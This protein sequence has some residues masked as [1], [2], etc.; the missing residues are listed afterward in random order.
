MH[1]LNALHTIDTAINSS[2]DLRFTYQ[3]LLEQ[4]LTL[5]KAGA[6]CVIF[7]DSELNTKKL[8]TSLGFSTSEVELKLILQ[9]DP[10]ADRAFIERH[11]VR[12]TREEIISE[13]FPLAGLLKGEEIISYY[14]V[15][16]IVKGYVKGVLDLFF[17][18]DDEMD[19]EVS[20]FLE[21]IAQQAAIALESS[22]NFERLQ[23][24]N[25]E[26]LQAYDDTLAGWVNFLDLRDEKTGG[27][28][29]RVLE[30]TLKICRAFGFSSQELL[31]IHRGVLLHDIGKIGVPDN[32]LNKPG[33]LT[34]AE[35]VIMKKHPV[36]AYQ[37]L[38]P[39]SYL[40]PSLDIPYCH[41]EKWDG[42][43]YPRGLKGKEIPLSARIFA[44]VDVYDALTSD[45]PY[46][47]A[48]KKEVVVKYIR[49][50]S[51]THFDPEITDRCIDLLLSDSQEE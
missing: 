10:L 7:F 36:Y 48:W 39:I 24:N 31:H 16:L 40:R 21:T 47:N 49:E 1:R 42:T 19:L 34:D 3:V 5:T 4:V 23:K 50:Q 6:A 41:H 11:I 26:L 25:Q 17:R 43:G 51:G 14:V 29:M 15:P 27:H 18:D 12:S 33:P 35:W 30:S 28:T 32:I 22:Q 9:K 37:M 2:F 44:I 8:I 45:R 46:R 13:A 20:N 38:Y